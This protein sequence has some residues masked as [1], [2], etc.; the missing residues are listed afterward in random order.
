MRVFSPLKLTKIN[1]RRARER[2][3]ERAMPHIGT[4][5]RSRH[6]SHALMRGQIELVF[7]SRYSRKGL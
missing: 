2:R 7:L 6:S 4:E 5:V 3:S 1:A